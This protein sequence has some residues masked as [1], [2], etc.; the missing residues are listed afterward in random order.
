[1][2]RIGT[3]SW[4][5]DSWRGILYSGEPKINY[6]KEYAAH[7]NTVEIDQ[8]FW[9]LHGPKKVTL[10]NPNVVSAYKLSVPSDFKFTVKVPNSITLT[11]F[12]R[13]LKQDPLQPNPHFLSNDLFDQ[14]LYLIDPLKENIGRLMFQFEYLNKQKM[15][16]QLEFQKRFVKFIEKCS[17]DFEYSIEIRNP[18]YLNKEYFIFLEDN[19]LS[20]IFLQGYYMPPIFEVFEEFKDGISNPIIRLHGPDRKEIET[21]SGG[22]WNKIIEPKDSELSK[23]TEMIE[24]LLNS[25]NDIYLN[26]NNHYEGSA[27]LTIEKIKELLKSGSL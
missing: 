23:I 27:P 10:P 18:N 2:L 12:Y 6:L 14:F 22:Q 1:M 3:C 24:I 26:V 20:H 16:S 17:S 9:S 15:A 11:H 7:Y 21:K 8:W 25:G 19:N 5:Y 13:K 4:K